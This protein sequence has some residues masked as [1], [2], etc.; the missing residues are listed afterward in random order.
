M[1]MVIYLEH[2]MLVLNKN[3]IKIVIYFCYYFEKSKVFSIMRRF[4]VYINWHGQFTS[5]AIAMLNYPLSGMQSW[6]L[7]GCILSK[8]FMNM[9]I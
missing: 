8:A 5:T 7:V 6:L 1:K 3:T 2:G 4:Q 9:L